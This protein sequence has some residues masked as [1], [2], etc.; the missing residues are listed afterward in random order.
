MIVTALG[1]GPA[2]AERYLQHR[3]PNG[4]TLLAERMPG[5][6]SAAMTLLVNAGVINDP[7]GGIG[8]ANVL[9]D[10]VLKGAGSRNSRELTDHLDRLGLQ[11]SSGAGIHHTR[12]ACAAV[13]AN[14]L[15]GMPTYADIVQRPHL[16]EDGFEASR[17]LALQALAGVDDDP[18]QKVSIKLREIFFPD[19]F[20]RN[21]MGEADQLRA[22]DIQ[23][24]KSDFAARYQPDRAILSIA[25]NIEF[26][27]VIE[28]AE[29]AFGAWHAKP[30]PPVHVT[31]SERQYHFEHQKSEQTHIGIAYPTLTENEENYYVARMAVEVLSG[32]MSGRLFTEVREKRALCYS[33]GASYA[34]VRDFACVFG[35]AG[36]SNDRAQ[37]TLD[38]FIGE[39]HRLSEGVQE[40]EL[41]RAKIG[42]KS[43]TIMQEE[44]TSAR[45]GAMAADWFIRGRVRTLDEIAAAIDAITVD[46]VNN[47]LKA[48]K[49]G[50]FTIVIVGPKEL[51]LAQ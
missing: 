7:A 43:N 15:A 35:Y 5:M 47:Y 26:N 21:T 33:V 51:K 30:L 32:G 44:S 18:R 16:P 38:C 22:L 3:L 42:L 13:A 29:A 19:P 34:S 10:L 40:D 41:D 9:S 14:V 48:N 36:T 24:I 1:K 25:G 2:L 31:P 4:L 17:D 20:G 6:Q 12:F 49:P 28:K 37:A 27:D 39:L 8:S 46:Q 45:A 23:K 50:P 11:R